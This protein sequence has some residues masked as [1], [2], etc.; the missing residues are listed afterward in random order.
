M[1]NEIISLSTSA[2]STLIASVCP[3]GPQTKVCPQCFAQDPLAGVL[4]QPEIYLPSCSSTLTT[5]A[6]YQR[7]VILTVGE[8]ACVREP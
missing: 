6:T 2:L 8:P 1:L 7:R 3:P 4:D 5:Q